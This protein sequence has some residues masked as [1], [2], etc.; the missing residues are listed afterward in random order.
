MA[1]VRRA[2]REAL[3]EA[4]EGDLV[5]VACSG[6]T[7]SLA[8][9]AAEEFAHEDVAHCQAIGKHGARL[10]RS[11]DDV[12]WR[13]SKLGLHYDERHRAAVADWCRVQWGTT[14]TATETA[15]N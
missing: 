4:H 6:G 9:A 5:L 1:D 11:A 14:A 2:V 13:R 15:W 3:A 8:L 7:D 12:L 10:I